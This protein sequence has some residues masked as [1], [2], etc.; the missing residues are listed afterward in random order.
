MAESKSIIIRLNNSDEDLINLMKQSPLPNATFIKTLTR[1]AIENNSDLINKS[2]I[3]PTKIENKPTTKEKHKLSN[4]ENK[5][6]SG[7]GKEM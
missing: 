1:M 5:K 3:L 7:L 4:I 6:F 2:G